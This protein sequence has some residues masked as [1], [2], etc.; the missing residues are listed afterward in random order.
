MKTWCH[1]THCGMSAYDDALLRQF[2]NARG[3]SY[4]S[5]SRP[6]EGKYV[7]SKRCEDGWEWGIQLQ[8]SESLLTP[9]TVALAT[10]ALVGLVCVILGACGV[11]SGVPSSFAT[12][13]GT[14]L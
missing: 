5:T 7:Y 11:F 14:L 2:I 9:H 3:L 12:F 10:F 1:I 6:G 4:D 13:N 8:S